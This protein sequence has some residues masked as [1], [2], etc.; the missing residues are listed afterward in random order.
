[1]G[2]ETSE[3]KDI[4][5][6]KFM[7]FLRIGDFTGLS[8]IDLITLQ[9]LLSHEN[10]VVRHV[11][12][13]EVNKYI[14]HEE[15]LFESRTLNL[16]DTERLFYESIEVKKDLSTASFYNNLENLER[17]GLLCFN[18]NTAG[19]IETVEPSK[20]TNSVLK[21]ILTGLFNL[22]IERIMKYYFNQMDFILEKLE[23]N[24]FSSILSILLSKNIYGTYLKIVSEITKEAFV[25]TKQEQREILQ[26]LHFENIKYSRIIK[27]KI[28]EPED[29]FELAIIPTYLK[30]PRFYNFTRIDLLKELIRVVKPGGY[31]ILISGSDLD[32]SNNVYMNELI[33]I[34]NNLFRDIIF[35]EKE[36][37]ED[38]HKVGLSNFRIYNHNGI[39]VSIVQV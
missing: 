29:I 30:K 7:D 5:S 27:D 18:K 3:S 11:L 16:S 12:Y 34:Y 31:I 37:E 25:L 38:L 39:L 35:S 17:L 33:E 14:K 4:I 8:I 1:M 13:L 2:E 28:R 32:S 22:Y 24:H 26:K 20:L 10:P 19:K 6:S 21:I 9:I 15:E 23:K 36:I